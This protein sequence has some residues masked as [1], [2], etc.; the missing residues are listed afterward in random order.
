MICFGEALPLQGYEGHWSHLIFG[1]YNQSTTISANSFP[2]HTF[3]NV[4]I[5]GSITLESIEPGFL[6]G[7]ENSL[8][9]LNIIGNYELKNFE[10][11]ELQKFTD[12]QV[13]EFSWT[14]LEMLPPDTI[15]PDSLREIR[16]EGNQYFQS[17][18]PHSF[19]R[20]GP[21]V[22]LSGVSRVGNTSS[23]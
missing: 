23:P 7:S 1:S 15:W 19:L 5:S 4:Q 22:V 18:E 6:Q 17:I 10:F 16:I 14:G 20:S 3:E 12:L 21:V 2:R 9:Q 11:T 13:F 8:K